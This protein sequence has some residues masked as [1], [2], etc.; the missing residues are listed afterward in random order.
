MPRKIIKLSDENKRAV[1]EFKKHLIA[2]GINGV[3][4]LR[5]YTSACRIVFDIAKKNWNELNERD[6]DNIFSSERM[7]PMTRELYKSKF[8]NFLEYKGKKKLAKYIKTLYNFDVLKNPTKTV[9]DVLSKDEIKLLIDSADN[10]RD[11]AIIEILLTTGARRKE[12]NL[13]KIKDIKIN[14]Y[15]IS[16]T[17]NTSKTAPRTIAIVKNDKIVTAFWPYNFVDFYNTHIFK[18]EPEKPL[19]YS[20]Y[21]NRY[22][23][24]LNKNTI[25]EILRGIVKGL[26]WEKKITPHILRHTSATY[27]GHFLTEQDLCHRFGWKRHSKMPTFYCHI[28]EDQQVDHLLK[29]AGTTDEQVKKDSI[30]PRC[31]QTVNIN[32][33]ICKYCYYILDRTLQQEKIE[34]LTEKNKEIDK[35]K[36]DI[37]QLNIKY[38][39]ERNK[40]KRDLK[41]LKSEI[42]ELKEEQSEF[43]KHI[44]YRMVKEMVEK[45]GHKIDD[46]AEVE[47]EL[48]VKED[49]VIELKIVKL[50]YGK[51]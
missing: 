25:N 19:F 23:K 33:K 29:I 8:V 1:E 17:I 20:H 12:V 43:V 16:V 42:K 14:E 26:K 44:G 10:L 38:N 18:D 5:V 50:T 36:N 40:V 24:P 45:D 37:Y 15:S 7:K 11:K 39:K 13:L 3:D 6:I 41:K 9:D 22:G 28:S 48:S 51:Q 32:D 30:C 31:S 21:S 49:G 35:A 4:T 27:Y 2:N 34:E 46:V 47:T